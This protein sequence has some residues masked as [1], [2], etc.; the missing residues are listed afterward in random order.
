MSSSKGKQPEERGCSMNSLDK[1]SAAMRRGRSD[2]LGRSRVGPNNGEEV[3]ASK[4]CL[5]FV[6]VTSPLL[7]V[8]PGPTYLLNRST[9]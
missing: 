2:P 5:V 3:S 1:S 7:S 4:R 8:E 6:I 9:D